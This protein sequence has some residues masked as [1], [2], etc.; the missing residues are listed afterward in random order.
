VVQLVAS[1]AYVYALGPTFIDAQ[2]P[3]APGTT[4][5]ASS[6]EAS[7]GTFAM[8][9]SQPVWATAPSSPDASDGALLTI[10]A[11]TNQVVTLVSG[12]N[13]LGIAVGQGTI[14][15]AEPGELLK[16]PIG[17][18]VPTVIATYQGSLAAL[19]TDGTSLYWGGGANALVKV[20]L[21]GGTPFTLGATAPNAI[22]VD[23][24]S[25]Y[26]TTNIDQ[27]ELSVGAVMKTTPK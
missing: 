25:V 1:D 27:N 9:A 8:A 4:G 12:L 22:V 20:P 21:A 5:K 2:Y 10:P 6:Q 18:G 26:W 23:D 11:G 7:T 3:T 13:C 14:Y 16:M 17:G 19:T 15:F 24:T